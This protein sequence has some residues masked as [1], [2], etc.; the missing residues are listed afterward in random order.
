M[1]IISRKTIFMQT[2]TF[3]TFKVNM[4][5][6]VCQFM[7]SWACLKQETHPVEK[8]TTLGVGSFSN[9]EF[10]KASIDCVYLTFVF[11]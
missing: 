6:R 8:R 2:H 10:E 9:S 7:Q 5:V 11:L 1:K 4:Y 3:L